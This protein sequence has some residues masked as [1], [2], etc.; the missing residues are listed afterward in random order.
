MTETMARPL[1]SRPQA[2]A[3][4]ANQFGVFTVSYATEKQTKFIGAL[5][6]RKDLT[7]LDPV[8]VDVVALRTQVANTQVNKTAASAIIDTLL[9]LPDRTN[10][11]A[12]A[13]QGRPATEKQMDF[14]RKLIAEKDFYSLVDSDRKKVTWFNNGGH[15]T[16]AGASALIDILLVTA[17]AHGTEVKVELEKGDI[18]VVDGSYVRVHISQGTG[19]PYACVANIIR[20]AVWEDGKVVEPGEVEWDFVSGLV[21]KLS[22]ANKATPEQAKQFATLAGRCIYCSRAIDTPEST[23]VGYGPVC[24]V[25]YGLPWGSTTE[26]VEQTDPNA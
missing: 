24:A 15:P 12:T 4:A 8:K 16:A 26:V 21:T 9:A 11:Q 23:K 13:T 17:P 10:A 7:L 25:K 22:T 1:H 5:L 6:D 14:L 18:H 3:P 19:N 2:G 20:E